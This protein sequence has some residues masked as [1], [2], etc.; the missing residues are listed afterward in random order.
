MSLLGC[1]FPAVLAAIGS[2]A[3]PRLL[4]EQLRIEAFPLAAATQRALVD[5]AR[6]PP[7]AWLLAAAGGEER[8]GATDQEGQAKPP[9]PSTATAPG[10]LEFDLLGAPPDAKRVDDQA[11]RL[12]RKMLTWHQGLG[13]GMF[14][15]QLATTV[16]G[17]LNYDDKFN[18][19]NTG[20]YVQS[21]AVLAYSTL[22][23]FVAAGTLALLAPKPLE[24]REGFDR[25]SL[26]KLA[27][28]TAAAGMVAQGVLGIWTHSREGYVNQQGIATAHLVVGYVT[29]AA[30]ATGVSALVF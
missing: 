24:R 17:Q 10:A 13:L 12:R 20:R 8:P 30:V 23:T 18:G 19:G 5:L 3:G 28:F 16:V 26:H 27:M 15:L 22:A 6:S 14:A 1:L 2:S 11:L 21:H 7:P 4:A 9:Q 29:L 25:V